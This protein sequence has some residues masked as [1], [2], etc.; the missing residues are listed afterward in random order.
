MAND[1]LEVVNHIGWTKS[2]QLH[3]A[4]ISMGGM[5]AQEFAYLIPD[6]IASLSLVSTAAALVN[7]IVCS[8]FPSSWPFINVRFTRAGLPT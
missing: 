8:N 5:I 6:R 1:V 7:T 3:V 4:G 2:R